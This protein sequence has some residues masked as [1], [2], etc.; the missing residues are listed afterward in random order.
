MPEQPDAK[1]LYGNLSA[2]GYD[3]QAGARVKSDTGQ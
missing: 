3:A 2:D 1:Q